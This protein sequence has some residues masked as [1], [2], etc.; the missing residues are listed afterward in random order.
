MAA[1]L[2]KQGYRLTAKADCPLNE[3]ALI[4]DRI[5]YSGVRIVDGFIQSLD[6]VARQSHLHRRSGPQHVER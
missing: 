6:S 4:A 5:G 1:V 3:Q 2:F